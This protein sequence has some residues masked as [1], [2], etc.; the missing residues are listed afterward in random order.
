MRRRV[1]SDRRYRGA[2]YGAVW[3]GQKG[4]NGVAILPAATP[5]S[6]AN[7]TSR[8]PR[9]HAQPLHRGGGGRAGRRLPLPS[10]R[11]SGRDREVRLQA[12]LD[13]AAARAGRGAAPGGA[14]GRAR[15]RLERGSGGP[16]RLLGPG[17]RARCAPPATDP[18]RLAANPA[19]GLD[20]RA[21]RNA[22][23]RGEALHLLGLYRRLLAARRGLRID[24]LLCSPEAADRLR[25]A[26][27]DKWARAQEKASD[28]AP[29]WVELA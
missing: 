6:S 22:S 28:H 8:R 9:R 27:V 13:G 21:S 23:G 10:Q 20:R 26:S 1:A 7:R 15:R 17:N 24:H 3:H 12:Q 19:P 25:G 11:Q 18:R 16:R 2:G 29:T 14:A 4:F 5:P